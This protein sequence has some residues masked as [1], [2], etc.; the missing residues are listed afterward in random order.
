MPSFGL[1]YEAIF[2]FVPP[3]MVP[4]HRVLIVGAVLAYLAFERWTVRRHR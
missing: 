1:I 4:L 2:R 3:V